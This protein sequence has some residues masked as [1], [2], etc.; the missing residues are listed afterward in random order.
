MPSMCE[1]SV[2]PRIGKKSLLINKFSSNLPY[3][4][5]NFIFALVWSIRLEFKCSY[6]HPSLMASRWIAKQNLSTTCL[7]PRL[8]FLLL[9]ELVIADAGEQLLAGVLQAGLLAIFAGIVFV[10]LALPAFASSLKIYCSF[11]SPKVPA[12]FELGFVITKAYRWPL[13]HHNLDLL[14]LIFNGENLG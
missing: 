3:S 1:H 7:K 5:R 11:L 8:S 2:S 10:A 14:H 4:D 9:P 6:N 12:R 13:E